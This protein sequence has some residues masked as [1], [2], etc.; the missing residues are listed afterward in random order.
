[1]KRVRGPREIIAFPITIQFARLR[2]T[3]LDCDRKCNSGDRGRLAISPNLYYRDGHGTPE[4]VAAKVRAAGGVPDDQAVGDVAGAMQHLRAL[5]YINGKVGVFG[6]CSG[7][8]H[9]FLVACRV[10]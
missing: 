9:A 10:K 3:T 7:G 4:D 2:P 6:T 1:M 5:P 8:R